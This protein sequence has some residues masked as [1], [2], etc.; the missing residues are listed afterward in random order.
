MARIFLIASLAESLLNFRG[1]L[2][3][4]LLERGHEVV[5]AAPD[6]PPEV[7]GKLTNLGVRHISIALQRT[8]FSLYSDL[9]VLVELGWLM[10][11]EKPDVVLA[12]TI[13]PVVY[14]SIAAC[15]AGVPHIASM[16]TGL[17]FAFAYPKNRLQRLV[18][19]IAR[20]LYRLAMMCN[21]TVFFQNPDDEADFRNA[22][23]LRQ[24]QRIVRT[25]GSGVNLN[26]FVPMPLP[27][28]NI[29]FLMIARLLV[30]K[31]VREYLKAA[32]LVRH[33]RP[34]LEFH[35][36]GPF[37]EHPLAVQR[38][39]IEAAVSQ[40]HVVY[41]GETADVRPYL[42]SCHIYVLPSYRE[43]TPRSVLEAMAVGR[44]IITTDT[45][46]CRQTV[47]T[48]DNGFLVPP[49]QVDPLVQTML[50]VAELP[51]AEIARMAARSRELAKE[52]FDVQTVNSRVAE[53][54]SL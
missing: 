5:T 46:G 12:Y 1:D 51:C 37:D 18:G 24:T 26:H 35:I 17:G 25:G 14:G 52:H 3:R 31:G 45:P 34:D 15:W 38:A 9:R 6:A 23:M 16:I 44:V 47:I 50:K 36:I 30:D 28:G 42:A 49:R 21:E 43:G 10:R 22:G 40:T 53:A 7:E 20:G 2:I 39:E 33:V 41:H 4:H 29:R 11:T 19:M 48:G 54:L 32:A 8:G 13:K 27:S